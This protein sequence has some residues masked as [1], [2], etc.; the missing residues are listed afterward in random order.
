M[1]KLFLIVYILTYPFCL[2]AQWVDIPV[3]AQ[4]HFEDMA[5]LANNMV[6]V[7]D[8]GTILYSSDSGTS[9]SQSLLPNK[10]KLR[11]VAFKPN[12]DLVAV[13]DS[14]QILFS[15][16]TGHTWNPIMVTL[17]SLYSLRKVHFLDNQIGFITG[18][19]GLILKTVDG[20]TSWNQVTSFTGNN[21]LFGITTSNTGKLWIA[22]EFGELIVSGDTGLTWQI[23]PLQDSIYLFDIALPQPGV[24]VVSGENG[25]LYRS[26]DNGI[27]FDT[28][29]TN[30]PFSLRSLS[31]TSSGTGYVAGDNGT[32][33]RTSDAGLTWVTLNSGF[34][35]YL[36]KIIAVDDSI[37]YTAGQGG[38]LL[39]TS[40]SGG[41]PVGFQEYSNKCSTTFIYPNP[42]KSGF[43]MNNQNSGN[44]LEVSLYTLTGQMISKLNPV[45]EEYYMPESL[46]PGF[47]LVK[48][49][50]EN[51]EIVWV[52]LSYAP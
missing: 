1:K 32:I 31:F 23:I 3:P 38:L 28:V 42:V 11:G 19:S 43:K 6:L 27:T 50:K 24:I 26:Q 17:P 16:D 47:Y 52:K 14:S 45:N 51:K 10:K 20:G 35:N 39:Y 15:Q 37:A 21:W 40:N 9:W 2:M 12:A 44:N 46:N 7:G 22:G 8:S 30:T 34:T 48:V 29:I 4:N 49:C 18:N 13:G 33:L 36:W 25:H 41:Y 5:R